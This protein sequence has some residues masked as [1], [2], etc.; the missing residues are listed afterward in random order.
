VLLVAGM[1]GGEMARAS[2]LP[3]ILGYVWWAWCS[4]RWPTR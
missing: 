2:R 1:L 4:R 3:R